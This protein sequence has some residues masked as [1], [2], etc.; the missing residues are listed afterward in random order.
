[1][2]MISGMWGMA[3]K[4]IAVGKLTTSESFVIQS[5]SELLASKL[6]EKIG[7]PVIGTFVVSNSMT[8][9]GNI[10]LTA[11]SGMGVQTDILIFFDAAQKT[12][13]IEQRDNDAFIAIFGMPLMNALKG[14]DLGA[15]GAAF[16]SAGD[17]RVASGGAGSMAGGYRRRG[18]RASRKSGRKSRKSKRRSSKKRSSRKSRS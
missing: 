3:S 6:G 18:S 5:F 15:S 4:A 8:G 10:K 2:S 9:S 11:I 1:M 7:K 16:V 17:P 13:R 14:L 12:L